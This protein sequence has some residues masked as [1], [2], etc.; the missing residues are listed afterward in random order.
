[1]TSLALL[2]AL[3]KLSPRYR[4]EKTLDGFSLLASLNPSCPL[5]PRG[6]V[7]CRAR[8]GADR[9]LSLGKRRQRAA[10]G[11]HQHHCTRT[12]ARR[13]R[14]VRPHVRIRAIKTNIAD[15]LNVVVQIERRPGRRFISE[16][17]EINNYDPDADL[18]DFC[19]IYVA[20]REPA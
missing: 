16:V 9:Q 13:D 15:S 2:I 18:F 3:H 20:P 1:M 17:L 6:V 8:I 4:N 7:P 11:V 5:L 10:A 12:F 14:G 19:A